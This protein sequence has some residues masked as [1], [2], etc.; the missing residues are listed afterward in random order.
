[1]RVISILLLLCA[2]AAADEALTRGV[3]AFHGGRYAEARTFLEQS[4]DAQAPV[5][6]A[7]VQA[8][9]G[10]CD[11]ATPR[12]AEAFTHG[13]EPALRKLTGE[14]LMSCVESNLKAEYP[15]DADVLY[16]SAR[17]HLRAWNDV[18]YQMFQ[19]TPGSYRVNQI[20]GEVLEIQGKYHDAAAE[21]RKAIEKNPRA[22]DLHFRLG[23][24]ILI[25][26]QGP[27]ALENALREF[28][29]E[30]ALNRGDAAAEY[31]AGQILIAQG[32]RDAGARRLE[33]ALEL[34]PDFIEAMVAVGR[35]RVEEKR[36]AEAIALLKRATGLQPR[37]ET[38][39]YSLMMAYRNSGD[40]ESAKREKAVLDE[41]QKP[42]EGE[43]TD[44]LKKL[45]EKPPK[46]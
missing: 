9:T 2:A 26:S 21:Y 27:E 33:H 20:S 24:V 29:A 25:D 12:L 8:A 15:A 4:K 7:L 46:L 35:A 17:A 13:A 5:F 3:E 1:M 43:F 38:A 45:G 37:N 36:Y 32:K 23:R 22:L 41:L 28:E 18:V 10:G 39:H 42:P 34:R 16:Q 6:L 30:L 19:K 11:A 40:L 14:A 44:F 31:E